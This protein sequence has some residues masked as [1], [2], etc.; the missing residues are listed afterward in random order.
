MKSLDTLIEQRYSPYH[1]A[2]QP[3][4]QE[5]LQQLFEAAQHAPSSY[6]EQPW[7]FIYATHDQPEAYQQLLSCINESN[8]AWARQAYVLMLS[9][10]KKHFSQTEKLNRHAWHDTGTAVGFLLL[11]ATELDLY[12]HQ[13][14]G[15]FP[16]K[17]RDVLNIPDEYDPVAMMAVGYL[18]KEER[19]NKPRKAVHEFAFTGDK[20]VL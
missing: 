18:G 7:R 9:L 4:S 3:V 16:D 6:N 10:A 20:S 1:F 11:K 5:Q 19:P 13:M 12:A 15:F 17:A 2:E 14:A 8:R